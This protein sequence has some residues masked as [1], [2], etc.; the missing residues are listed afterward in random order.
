RRPDGA[1][2]LVGAGVVVAGGAAVVERDAGQAGGVRERH[3]LLLLQ[4]ARPLLGLL[5]R[6]EP[7]HAAVLVVRHDVLVDV[8]C[9][10]LPYPPIAAPSSSPPLVLLLPLGADFSRAPY[11]GRVLAEA[12]MMRSRIPVGMALALVAAALVLPTT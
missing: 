5:A 12:P 8:D 10:R 6:V 9:Y 7:P 11:G 2:P 1:P 4:F 3:R